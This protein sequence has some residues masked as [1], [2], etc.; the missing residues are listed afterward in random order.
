MG[1][2]SIRTVALI[3]LEHT[4]RAALPRT[5]FN[6]FF[7]EK[8]VSK[9]GEENLKITGPHFE[10]N[11]RKDLLVA[12]RGRNRLPVAQHAEPFLSGQRHTRVLRMQKGLD[13][14]PEDF[15]VARGLRKA[16]AS[17]PGR[18]SLRTWTFSVSCAFGQRVGLSEFRARLPPQKPACSAQFSP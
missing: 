14:T 10:A 18:V 6:S 2:R 5:A 15:G 11:H 3:G 12:V 8:R 17:W 1:T 4:S 7:M 13:S 16:K 9:S